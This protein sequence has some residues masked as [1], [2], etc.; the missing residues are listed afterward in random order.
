MRS[1][2]ELVGLVRAGG[3]D[4]GPAW[5]ELVDR[6]TPRLYGVA[7]S[8]D[9]DSQT[10]EDLVQTAW[11]RFLSRMDQLRDPS[12]LGPWL[13]MIVRKVT[14]KP[15]GTFLRERIFEPLDLTRT[16]IY[17]DQ[18]PLPDSAVGYRWKDDHYVRPPLMPTVDGKGHAR[19]IGRAGQDV[20]A[21]QS[22]S[23]S[24]DR[25]AAPGRRS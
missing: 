12:S 23:T 5:R 22:T 3:R 13:G 6:H 20:V 17:G 21:H 8:F 7:R 11:L 24:A 25:C 9:V 18:P 14:G 19:G 10:A 16:C 2:A 15:Y 4:R 1:D